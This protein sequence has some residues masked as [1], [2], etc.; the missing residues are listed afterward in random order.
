M[1]PVFHPKD[2][3]GA[4]HVY[5]VSGVSIAQEVGGTRSS[6]VVYKVDS[7]EV[8]GEELG[9]RWA[10][11]GVGREVGGGRG[12]WLGRVYIILSSLAC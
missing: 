9:E 6:S 7:D 3:S 11:R 8:A 5:P 1:A 10:G 12:V 4:V 2:I